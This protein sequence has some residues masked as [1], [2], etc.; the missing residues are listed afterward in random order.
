MKNL[1]S[2]VPIW[3]EPVY[4]ELQEMALARFFEG[5]FYFVVY[6]YDVWPK[7]SILVWKSLSHFTYMLWKLFDS[8]NQYFLIQ[9]QRISIFLSSW[10]FLWEIQYSRCA[11][12]VDW[13]KKVVLRVKWVCLKLRD[14]WKKVDES[15][16]IANC[17]V[18]HK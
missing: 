12:F 13:G 9:S 10:E 5:L 6:V 14:S 11:E 16:G 17:E 7:N 3:L 1:W 18:C 15:E 8:I 4:C 2:M